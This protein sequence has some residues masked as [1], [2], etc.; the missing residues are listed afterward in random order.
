MLETVE[1]QDVEFLFDQLMYGTGSIDVVM[2][3]HCPSA[4][5]MLGRIVSQTL[6]ARVRQFQRECMLSG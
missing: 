2:S 6:R 4:D 3:R 5:A 1:M